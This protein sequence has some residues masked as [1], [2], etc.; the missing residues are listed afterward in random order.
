MSL[1]ASVAGAAVPGNT[2]RYG[3]LVSRRR[4]LEG[5][6]KGYGPQPLRQAKNMAAR[7]TEVRHWSVPGLRRTVTRELA[8]TSTL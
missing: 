5:K 8:K 7:R 1:Q 4:T 2:R 3:R 6:E